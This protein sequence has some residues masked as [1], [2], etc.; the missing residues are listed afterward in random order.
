M[1]AFA[2]ARSLLL[3]CRPHI[4][5]TGKRTRLFAICERH[6]LSRD[7]TSDLESKAFISSHVDVLS[8][9]LDRSG[10]RWCESKGNRHFPSHHFE[11]CLFVVYREMLSVARLHFR[12][13]KNILEKF[14]HVCEM[15]AKDERGEERKG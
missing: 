3:Y 11:Q 8:V 2:I 10:Q 12:V 5:N 7:W 6:S 14:R 1:K 13:I 15:F 9:K 4:H